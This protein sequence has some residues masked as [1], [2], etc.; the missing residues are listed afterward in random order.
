M[1]LDTDPSY[2]AAPLEVSLRHDFIP[3]ESGLTG[4][5]GRQD[6]LFSWH[7]TIKGPGGD[8]EG[9]QSFTPLPHSTLA[10]S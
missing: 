8:Y 5:R 6:D 4:S 2:T 3:S 7:F 10:H 9:G 1:S